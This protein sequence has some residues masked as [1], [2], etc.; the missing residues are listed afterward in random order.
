VRAN[1]STVAK[2]RDAIIE[3]ARY[4]NGHFPQTADMMSKF[5]GVPAAVFN[6]MPR[7]IGA[8]SVDAK[9]LQP[10]IDTCAKYKAIPAS[11][12][13]RELIDPALR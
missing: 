2:F 6:S 9:E 10:L 3:S 7:V 5:T 8:L 1:A 4:V 12:D 11:F 13:A